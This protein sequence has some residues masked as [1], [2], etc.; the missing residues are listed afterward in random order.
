MSTK[1]SETY[2]NVLE[3]EHKQF[4]DLLI[5]NFIDGYRNNTFKVCCLN[6]AWS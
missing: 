6:Y 4:S 3:A 1:E 5:G 2:G